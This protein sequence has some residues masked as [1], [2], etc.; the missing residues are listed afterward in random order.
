M[1]TT[2]NP[3]IEN[4][5][6]PVLQPKAV[7]T[8]LASIPKCLVDQL[9]L[10]SKAVATVDCG[11][12][13]TDHH[14]QI[15]WVNPAFSKST[16]YPVEELV[17]KT[18]RILKSGNHDQGYYSE[19]WDTILRGE[20]WHG[21]F[22]NRRR[23]G[24]LCIHAQTT[25]PVRWQSGGPITHFISISE[26]ITQGK[27][28][29]VDSRDIQNL[30]AVGRL[31]AGV[32]HH[33]NNLL[34]VIHANS[35][36]LLG[37]NGS[38]HPESRS[39]VERTLAASRRAE[40]LVRQLL[41][42]S[43][44]R[45]FESQ[46]LDLNRVIEY[47]LRLLDLRANS[48]VEPE[49]RY[50]DSLPFVLADGGMLGR[51]ICHLVV[52]ALDAMPQ[53]GRLT[54][55]TERVVPAPSDIRSQSISHPGE[56]VCLTIGDT[57]CGIPRISLP[58]I[59][60]PFFTT[61]DETDHSG[62]GLAMVYGI[63]KQ[64]QGWAEVSSHVG[65]GTTIK[66]FLP[67]VSKS[68]ALASGALIAHELPGLSEEPLT[69][70]DIAVKTVA[71]TAIYTDHE[72]SGVWVNPAFSVADLKACPAQL[73]KFLPLDMNE[74]I[75][76]QVTMLR[77]LLDKDIE[78]IFERSSDAVWVC[79]DAILVERVVR[80]LCNNARDEMSKGGR[81]TLAVTTVE[82]QAQS[83]RPNPDARPGRFA[84]LTVSNTGCGIDKT[85]LWRVSEPSLTAEEVGKRIGLGLD[86]VYGIVKQCG[87][88]VEVDSEAGRGSSFRVYLPGT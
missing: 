76:D 23:D 37:L 1:N 11:M 24:S 8:L 17:G 31:A 9:V 41:V 67:G 45:V 81:L 49:I 75:H 66:I 21:Q 20:T 44:R 70:R 25:T 14:G 51:M 36:L 78:I 82:I 28:S 83:T 46:A 6:Q 47:T 62:L 13:I 29:E 54:I 87:G 50:C 35:E 48:T 5:D 7:A 56:F 84:C 18:P 52:N 43:E 53:G 32:A 10:Q 72:D 74:L 68:E 4:L 22:V 19:F 33:F 26:D 88:W 38:L 58:R 34:T 73:A 85:A 55:T 30:D 77:R 64:H 16:G 15:M 60:E 59:F 57:G 63:V 79:A 39:L 71:N 65:R 86:L 27:Q 3:E 2:E 69:P 61:K 12:M 42:F 80:S 40:H